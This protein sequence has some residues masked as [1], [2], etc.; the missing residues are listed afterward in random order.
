MTSDPPLDLERFRVPATSPASKPKRLPRHRKGEWFLKGPIPGE[1]INRA[2]SLS[3]KALHV[4]LAAWHEGEMKKSRT[5]KLTA[6]L[7]RLFG[8]KPT[9]ARRGLA[10]LKAAG[11]VVVEQRRGCSPL[12]TILESGTGREP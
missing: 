9:A 1:W 11:L 4:A 7:L 8:V 2:A 10:A 12:V 6:G 5:V 3:G